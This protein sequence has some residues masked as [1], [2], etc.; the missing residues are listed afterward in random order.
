MKKK[1]KRIVFV[2]LSYNMHLSYHHGIGILAAAAK[3]YGAE[4][5]VYQIHDD[6]GHPPIA[7]KCAKEISHCHADFICISTSSLE[8]NFA[9][10]LAL[11]LRKI[12]DAKLIV[13]GP[14]PTFCSN[15]SD[16]FELFDHVVVGEGE[17][18]LKELLDGKI[19]DEKIINGEMTANLDM[20]PFSDRD[21]FD[22]KKI[23]TARQGI[24]D[25][26]TQRGCPHNCSFCSNHALRKIYGPKYLRRRSVNNV[27][28]E[29][30][31][32]IE[33]YQCKTIFFHD[34]IFTLNENWVKEF[35]GRY[36]KEIGLP[37][38]INS[39]VDHVKDELLELL[40][41]AGCVEI[42][43]G[44]ES[45]D[46]NTRNKV[47]N[48]KIS[49]DKINDRFKAARKAGIRTFAFMM[50]GIPGEAGD[51]Y[52][53]SVRLMAKIMPNVIRST[54]FFPL[55]N[56][57]LGD[58]FFKMNEGLNLSMLGD[59][60]ASPLGHSAETLSKFYLFGWE[61]NLA[62]GLKEYEIPLQKYSHC[63]DAAELK[64]IDAIISESVSLQGRAH[65]QFGGECSMLKLIDDKKTIL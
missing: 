33:K 1:G 36:A 63:A 31:K 3:Q 16:G 6:L 18:F 43:F 62:L 20:L 44:I 57:A 8:W 39:H 2:P 61:I 64:M 51:S 42:K 53:K 24:V 65:Y 56:T 48:K 12:T 59:T 15:F 58:P 26:L 10:I 46:E 17:H 52:R 45:G 32:V 40:A 41:Q 50:H 30:K 28:E 27:I 7:E 38:M 13:G 4:V 21:S 47:L 34:D 5:G 49:D 29:I 25:F 60:P 14:H 55:P 22:M 35:C 9:K 11:E 37:W 23:I 19:N 54:V